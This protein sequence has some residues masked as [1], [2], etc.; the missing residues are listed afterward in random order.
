MSESDT[1]RTD[2]AATEMGYT[3]SHCVPA[4]FARDQERTIAELVE[5][6][7]GVVD[8]YTALVNCGDCGN[9]D[10]EREDV[11]VHARAAIARAEK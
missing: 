6:L 8:R 10:P 11:I 2:A 9:W 5:A 3:N 7:S 1:P 4:D